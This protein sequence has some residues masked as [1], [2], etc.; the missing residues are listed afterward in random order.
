MLV[1][2]SYFSF[3]SFARDGSFEAVIEGKFGNVSK[4]LYIS[5]FQGQLPLKNNNFFPFL[6]WLFPGRCMET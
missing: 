4:L 6:S 1:G 5:K 2:L 3:Q